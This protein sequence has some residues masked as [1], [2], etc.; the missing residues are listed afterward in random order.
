MRKVT[1][2]PASG[3]AE[4][5]PERLVTAVETLLAER[6]DLDVSLRDITAAAGTNVAAVNYHFGS[7]DALVTAVIERAL[8]AHAGQQLA[9]LRAAR[10]AER[11]D[12]EGVVRAWIGPSVEAGTALIPRVAARVVSGGSPELRELGTRTH[13]ETY[14]LLFALL[15]ERLPA[16]S[17]AELTFRVNMAATAVASM[18]VGPFDETSVAGRPPVARDAH[19]LDR[20]VRFI[21]AGLQAPPATP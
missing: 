2:P 15:A 13:A 6:P 3:Q 12:L 11:C 18:I 4:S 1:L 20:A 14:A 16:L 19:T 9:A 10:A 21:V 8:T 17:T 5:T 7:K